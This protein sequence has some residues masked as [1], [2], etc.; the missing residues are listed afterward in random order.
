[1]QNAILERLLRLAYVRRRTVLLAA[2]ALLVISIAATLRVSFDT[3]IVRLLPRKGPVVGSFDLYLRHFGTFDRLYI[4]FEVPAGHRVSEGEDFIDRYV[5]SLRKSPEIE[6]VDAALFDDVKDWNY[7]LDREFL[8]LGPD[9]LRTALERFEPSNM[10]LELSKSRSLLAVSAPEVKAY[11]QHD[12]LNLAPLLRD[13]LGRGRALVDFDPTQTGYVS[14]DGRARLVMAKPVRPPFDTRFCKQLF[15]RLS[16]VETAAHAVPPENADDPPPTPVTVQVAG[17]YRIALDAERV[18]RREM[19][20]NTLGSLVGLMLLVFAVFRTSRVLIYGTIPL[21][22]AGVFTFGVNGL[23]GPLSP[24]ASGSAAMLFGLGIDGVALLYIRYVE[25]RNNGAGAEDAFGRSAGTARSIMLAFGTT[26]ATFF[27]LAVVDFPSLRE[28]GLIVG[29][30]ILACYVLLV[31]LVPALVGTTAPKKVRPVTAAW[32][33]RFVERRGRAILVCAAILT[34]ALGA[35]ATRIRVNT[36]LEKLQART[37]GTELEQQVADRFSLPRD[38]V[39]A[40][41]KG[42]ALDPLLEEADRLSSAMER[43]LPAVVVSA[44][45]IVLPPSSEQDAVGQVLKQANLDS[46]QVARDLE[47]QAQAAG[48]RPG[49]F[50]PFLD[51][52]PQTLSPST[53]ITYEGLVAHGLAPLLSRYVVR[54]P[55]GYLVVV[56]L[57]PRTAAELDRASAIRA[58]A[59]PS[60]NLTGMTLVNGELAR[61]FLPQFLKGMTF[62]TLV[63]ALFMYLVFRSVRHT[64]LAFLPTAV[65]FVWSAGLLALLGFELD[66][67]SLFAAMTFIGIATD[68]AIYVIHRFS[69]EGTR[70]MS[71]VLTA[72]G[73]GVL[74]ACGT[75]LIG[76]GSL[77]NST[78]GPLRSFGITSVTTIATCLVAALLVLPALLQE[79]D[80]S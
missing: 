58:A 52:L 28:L 57:Y 33:G 43:E 42:P 7:L 78:Y 54:V 53:R 11:V 79:T 48:F 63:V 20:F 17:G 2:F 55:D 3:N 64:L 29:I 4:L 50:G 21:V 30:G 46:A 15:A 73:G 13:R 26:A 66:M 1:M 71:A 36:S 19:V 32:L 65:G 16:A 39:L 22:L 31:A 80:R 59:A 77:I 23:A 5:E 49:A 47:R 6:S 14:R 75:T 76:F 60:F 9:N 62:G 37:A 67:F 34:V 56:Y 69:I 61:S 25:E 18:I 27:G 38:V 44:P 35:A 72:T 68:Y 10:A 74:V 41:G 51:R 24:V 70:P 45:D 40:L 12:P 8:L